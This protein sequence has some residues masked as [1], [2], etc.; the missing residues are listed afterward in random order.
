MTRGDKTIV[1]AHGG[2][3]IDHLT[4]AATTA[5]LIATV[6]ALPG[7]RILDSTADPELG[8]YPW[9]TA[10]PIVLDTS[11]SIRLGYVPVGSGLDLLPD[12][13]YWVTAHG[14]PPPDQ[15]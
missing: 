1:L 11:A 12:E 5:A 7:Q 4:A 8:R 14:E 10:H 3:T 13:I 9:L 2:A 6:A 15:L